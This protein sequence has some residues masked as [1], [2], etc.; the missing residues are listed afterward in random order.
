[1]KQ[2]ALLAFLAGSLATAHAQIFDISAFEYTQQYA[3][4]GT[5]TI[6]GTF[7]FGGSEQTFTV[8]PNNNTNTLSNI[9][10]STGTASSVTFTDT[11]DSNFTG[12]GQSTGDLDPLL[13]D[14]C[15][16]SN[17]GSTDAS[18]VESFDFSGLTSGATYNLVLYTNNYSAGRGFVAT[19][20][21]SNEAQLEGAPA[22]TL[23]STY[24]PTISSTSGVVTYDG[25][26]VEID[27]ITATGGDVDIAVT[28]NT[29]GNEFQI[30][31]AG[32]QLEQAPEP[33]VTALMMVG[34]GLVAFLGYRRC[35]K[36]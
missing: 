27:G 28:E 25:N 29:Q 33:G 17:G 24:D 1:M 7:V 34:A 9:V 18:T 10:D 16:G 11:V 32:M 23:T 19:V 12:D 30:N 6:D 15:V 13:F 36:A 14:N 21:G 26:Y 20:N 5:N 2:L 31:L 35:R 3:D 22:S 8:M 4:T